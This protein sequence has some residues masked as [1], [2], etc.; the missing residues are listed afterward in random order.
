M[1]S[2][3]AI[4]RG[5]LVLLGF[6]V[7]AWLLWSG[8]TEPLLLG[9]GAFSCL[10]TLIVVWRMGYFDREIFALTI[11]LRLL[12]YWCWLIKEIVKSSLAVAKV[13]LDP[14]LP[15]SARYIELKASA[16][17]PIGQVIFANS[18]TLTPGTLTLDLYHGELKVHALTQQGAD[19]LMSG[20]MDRRVAKLGER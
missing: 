16:P 7:A 5:V 11:S 17:G 20:E 8:H 15:I 2:P 13:V 6:L 3:A 10:A 4:S 14:R 19:D 12:A 18:I 9:L 1:K